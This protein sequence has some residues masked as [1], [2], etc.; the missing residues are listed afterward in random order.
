MTAYLSVIR[1]PRVERNKRYP[2]DEVIIITIPAVIALAQ[3]WEES[4]GGNKWPVP[5]NTWNVCFSFRV[6]PPLPINLY[7]LALP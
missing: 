5:T 2:L 1:D 6:S 4:G 7:A 3:G